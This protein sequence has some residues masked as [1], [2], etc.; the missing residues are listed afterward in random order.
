MAKFELPRDCAMG[1]VR[2]R[3]LNH[4]GL[5]FRNFKSRIW[6]QYGHKDKTPDW[7]KYPLLKPYCSGFEKYK[8]L[9]EAVKMSQENKMNAKKKVLHHTAGSRGYAGKQETWQRRKKKQSNWVLHLRQLT[10]LNEARD[11]YWVMGL[12]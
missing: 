12:F 2:S 8:Q 3:T 1:L 6:S 5:S 4:L 10:G 9:E 11:S 7:Y